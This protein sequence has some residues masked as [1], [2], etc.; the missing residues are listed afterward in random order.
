MKV[1]KTNNSYYT[2]SVI[3]YVSYCSMN[4]GIVSSTWGTLKLII[5]VVCLVILYTFDMLAF[6]IFCRHYLF[7]FSRYK[8]LLWSSLTRQFQGNPLYL[9]K[10]V[11]LNQ[12]CW[13][14]H[15]LSPIKRLRFEWDQ[16]SFSF[17][18]Y[19][20]HHYVIVYKRLPSWKGS[21][22]KNFLHILHVSS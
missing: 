17:T 2:S 3:F 11:P 16:H 10:Q 6:I 9:L 21:E 7:H 1:F 13:K 14:L 8:K 19:W 18:I 20:K 4:Q 22:I 5:C 12:K 15:N